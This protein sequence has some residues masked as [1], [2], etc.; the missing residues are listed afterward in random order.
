MTKVMY[1]LKKIPS[2]IKDENILLTPVDDVS[3]A[4]VTL[5]KNEKRNS[6]YNLVS[7]SSPTIKEYMEYISDIT[8]E[9]IKNL[10]KQLNEMKDDE[11]MQFV[12]MYL[13]GIIKDAEKLVVHVHSEKT[14]QALDNLGFKW[15]TIDKAYVCKWLQLRQG[16]N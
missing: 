5:I 16:C 14:N 3:R 4:I 15:G 12:A 6:V 2:E 10:Y 7:S 11:E 8:C 9:P 1:R 13:A